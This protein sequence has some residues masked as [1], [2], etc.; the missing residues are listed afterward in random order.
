MR[1]WTSTRSARA[2]EA[3]RHDRS[4]RGSDSPR[5]D[6]VRQ[7]H[8]ARVDGEIVVPVLIRQLQRVLHR[9]DAG[10]GDEDLAAAELRQRARKGLLDRVA[11]AHIDAD[12]DGAF[13]EFD[14]GARGR[15]D[16]DVCHGDSDAAL[17]QR[18]RD[19][20]ANALRPAG[21]KRAPAAK[22][23]IR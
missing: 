16:V 5:G 10:V 20:A 11:P 7:K 6:L 19:R 13:P 8:P 14:G 21:Y 4:G 15:R 1:C 9:R 2:P 12:R 17:R 3:C 23:G 18:P 22:L